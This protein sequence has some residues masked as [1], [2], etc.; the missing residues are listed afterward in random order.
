[1]IVAAHSFHSVSFTYCHS[2]HTL[3]GAFSSSQEPSC[4]VKCTGNLLYEITQ[5]Y[6][7][8]NRG[9]RALP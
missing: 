9:E 1:M 2:E 4:A 3:M 5:Y 7:P 8:Y 6:L